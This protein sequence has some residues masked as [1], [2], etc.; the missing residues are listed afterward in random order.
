MLS[1]AVNE[2]AGLSGGWRAKERVKQNLLFFFF[3]GCRCGG[4][5]AATEK[6]L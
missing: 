1:E 5:F 4:F 6:T 3:A 2:A